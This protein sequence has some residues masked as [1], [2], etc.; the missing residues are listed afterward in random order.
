CVGS[1]G[2]R[3]RGMR[4]AAAKF[5][6]PGYVYPDYLYRP[7]VQLAEMLARI[8]PGKLA[9]SYRTTGGTES[10]E[11]ALQI[12]MAYTGRG[13]LVSIEESYHGNSIATMSIGASDNR[14]TF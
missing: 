7:W 9:V 6:G 12:A 11:G 2:W 3:S 10:V 5:H 4:G 1:R 8:T 13:K 14:E